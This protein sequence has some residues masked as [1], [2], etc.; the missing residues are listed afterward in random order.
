MKRIILALCAGASVLLGGCAVPYKPIELEQSFWQERQ[1]VIGV[2]SSAVPPVE[3]HMAG[4]QGLLDI[5]I[6]KGNAS[7]MV[8]QMKKLSVERV[9]VI[10][11]NFADGLGRRGFKVMKLDPIDPAKLPEF[12]PAA[13]PE[14]YASRDFQSL[15]EK[16]LDRV[17][18][19]NVQRIGTIR[20]YQ[21]FIPLGAPRAVFGVTGQL[22]DVKT[23]KLLWHNRYETQAAIAE[24]WDQEPDFPNVSAAV[25]KNMIEGAAQFERSLFAGSAAK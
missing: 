5:A 2:V 24:P 4:A 12:K 10:P 8:D 19:V 13:N 7:K 18:F 14:L 1:V 16:G 22:I 17:L 20:S 11:A 3:A 21:G 25:T 23:N 15:K 6:N 9:T